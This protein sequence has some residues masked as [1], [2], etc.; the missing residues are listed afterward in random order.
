MAFRPPN[1]P[2]YN[3]AT[4]PTSAGLDPLG[5]VMAFGRKEL[6]RGWAIGLVGACILHSSVVAQAATNLV[7]V[8]DFAAMVRSHTRDRLRVVYSIQV[9]DPAPPPP[10]P[11]PEPEPEPQPEPTPLKA[12]P[13]PTVP[14]AAP[15]AAPAEE[16][17]PA[18]EAGKLLTAA[19]DPNAPLDLTGEGFVTGDG[20]R[21]AGGV[22]AVAGTSKT[23]VRNP[24]AGIGDGTGRRT[25]VAPV[26]PPPGP[27]LSRAPKPLGTTWNDCGFPPEADVEQINF[28]RV[29][30]VVTVDT[31]GRAKSAR[32]LGDPG[33][34]FG[35][36]AQQCALRKR[37]S[38][39][40][41]AQGQAV[42]K[43]TPPFVITFER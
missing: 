8:R 15:E 30:L 7:E 12:Q 2:P 19:P 5:P 43:S 29:R 28:M 42:V 34:G 20:V 41:D 9:A 37:Y 39:G 22:T 1:R 3:G 11:E 26:P 17:P 40:L 35:Q 38:V 13:Q 24:A 23:A 21:F 32:V 25:N 14:K 27:D 36:R 16:P 10:E 31:D 18:A 6:A 4:G 33:Y